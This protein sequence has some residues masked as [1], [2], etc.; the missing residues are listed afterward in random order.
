MIKE[1]VNVHLSNVINNIK[2]NI[3]AKNNARLQRKR[4]LLKAYYGGKK[5]MRKIIHGSTEKNNIRKRQLLKPY[6][7]GTNYMLQVSYK[8][9][10]L[11]VN[12]LL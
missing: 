7:G 1:L 8:T 12:M 5:Y 2:K 3:Y 4:Q 6:Y 11:P 10:Y 9:K